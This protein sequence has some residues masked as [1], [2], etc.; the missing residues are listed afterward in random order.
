V[1]RRARAPVPQDRRLALVRDAHGLQV[2]DGE[3]RPG[4]RLGDHRLGFAPDLLAVML[5][6]AGAR[7]DLRVLA[8]RHRDDPA[9][10]VEDDEARARGALVDGADDVRHDG[11]IP[12]CLRSGAWRPCGT[13]VT[14]G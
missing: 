2:A 13:V 7:I 8:L 12:A 1:Q 14:G 10:A 4:E 6:E 9:V 3:P 11:P 5:H